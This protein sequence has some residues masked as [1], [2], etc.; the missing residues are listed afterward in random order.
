[1]PLTYSQRWTEDR[2]LVI[3]RVLRDAP[4]YTANSSILRGLLEEIGHRA[5]RD[6]IAGDIDWLAEQ[7]LVTVAD[8]AVPGLR[9]ITLTQRGDDVAGGA[10]VLSGVARPSPNA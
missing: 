5:S 3:L 2:R 4:D 6:V 10:T 8:L 1:M 7:G 9:M